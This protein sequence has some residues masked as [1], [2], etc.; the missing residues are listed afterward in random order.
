MLRRRGILAV[1]A[2]VTVAASC[3][4]WKQNPSP[5]EGVTRAN[6][7]EIRLNLADGSIVRLVN[8]SVVADSVVGISPVTGARVAVLM[9]SVASTETK[10]VSGGR[11][12]LL[13]GGVL[14]AVAAVAGVV[15]VIAVASAVFGS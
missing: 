1:L 2:A 15:L 9:T 12:A 8:A 10:G 4:T 5:R 14:L 7:G 13:G 6:S 3:T 11:T